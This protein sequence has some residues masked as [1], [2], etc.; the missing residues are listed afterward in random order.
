MSFG[1][2]SGQA[3][4]GF[5]SFVRNKLEASLAQSLKATEVRWFW[6]S[7]ALQLV[8]VDGQHPPSRYQGDAAS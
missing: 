6:S 8:D 2:S 1:S 4:I 3:F 7:A 5:W